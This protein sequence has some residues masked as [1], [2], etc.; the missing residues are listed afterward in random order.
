MGLTYQK[1]QE[2]TLVVNINAT[3]GCSKEGGQR[4]GGICYA[5]TMAAVNC[6]PNF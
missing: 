3:E 4:P 6:V 5:G 2:L 1:I